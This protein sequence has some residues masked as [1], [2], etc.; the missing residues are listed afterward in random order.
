MIYKVINKEVSKHYKKSD[1]KIF[2]VW[3]HDLKKK[4]FEFD[5]NKTI[6]K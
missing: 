2:R 4:D 3:E 6:K 1:W 5:F